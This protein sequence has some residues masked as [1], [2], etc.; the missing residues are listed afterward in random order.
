MCLCCSGRLPEPVPR[1][2]VTGSGRGDG[3]VAPR[4]AAP[5]AQEAPPHHLHRGAAGTTRGY[6]RQDALPRRRAQGA[7]RAQGRPQGGEGRGQYSVAQ[8]TYST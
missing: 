2:H 7:A 4:R 8:A 3:G 5:Q 1:V 6:L